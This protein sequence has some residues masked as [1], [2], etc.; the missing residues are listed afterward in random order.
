VQRADAL[1]VRVVSRDRASAVRERV[2][3][4]LREALA[5]AGANVP[6]RVELVAEIVREPGDAAKF[7][8]AR[9]EV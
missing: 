7:K 5:E 9:S 8:L 4:A 6:V 1:V 3:A 2:D